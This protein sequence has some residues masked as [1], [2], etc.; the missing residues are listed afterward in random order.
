VDSGDVN[1]NVV[2]AVVERL[3]E[4]PVVIVDGM[5]WGVCRLEGEG[6][7]NGGLTGGVRQRSGR[8]TCRYAG[9]A[10]TEEGPSLSSGQG[11][12]KARKNHGLGW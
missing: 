5:G 3:M 11:S 1:G 7:G 9:G 8:V 2:I 10:W 6:E 4:L 12:K